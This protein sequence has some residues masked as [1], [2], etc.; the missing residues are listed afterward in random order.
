[1]GL[2]MVNPPGV[3]VVISE[4]TRAATLSNLDLQAKSSS[5]TTPKNTDG[6][7]VG[8]SSDIHISSSRVS[9]QD[10]CVTFKGGANRVTVDK[11]TCIGSH[12]MSIGSLGKANLDTVS[13][14]YVSNAHMIRSTKAAG[15]KTWPVG[16]GH[17]H[18][19]VQN[20]TFTRFRVEDCEY[21]IQIQACY[22][23]KKEYCANHAADAK[24]TGIVFDDFS[25][26]TNKKFR[27]V[28]SS[29]NCGKGGRCDVKVSKYS[30]QSSSGEG[31]VLCSN[32]PSTLGLKCGGAAVRHIPRR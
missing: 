15:I 31:K 26:T 8:K 3:F 7:V 14:I 27:P 25:G 20:A 28:T 21:A 1:M 18:G 4:G 30:V 22:G 24:L 9:N 11:M 5:R 19:V 10:D 2:K 16:N 17:G 23:E 32:T 6:F 12:G 29:F 13:N